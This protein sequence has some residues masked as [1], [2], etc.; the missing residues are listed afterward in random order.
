MRILKLYFHSQKHLIQIQE[1]LTKFCLTLFGLLSGGGSNWPPTPLYFFIVVQV[2]NIWYPFEIS[3]N[4]QIFEFFEYLLRNLVKQK[5]A[6][7]IAEI[8][9]I[10]Q[11]WKALDPAN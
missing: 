2:Y 5:Y 1:G 7:K 11:F 3:K 9:K 6:Q 10:K 8:E 4:W